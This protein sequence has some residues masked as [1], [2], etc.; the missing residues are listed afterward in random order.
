ML[1][2]IYTIFMAILKQ[3]RYIVVFKRTTPGNLIMVCGENFMGT[4][5]HAFC[6]LIPPL[7]TY[8]YDNAVDVVRPRFIWRC[9]EVHPPT[10]PK[11]TKNLLSWRWKDSILKWMHGSCTLWFVWKIDRWYIA[12]S[13]NIRGP[14][15][16]GMAFL[17][18]YRRLRLY[19]GLNST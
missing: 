1:S 18:R 6:H 2:Y 3:Y 13:R 12:I 10:L 16:L 9:R 7:Q 8:V 11:T 17:C 15:Q 14:P 19:K 4:W 5:Y